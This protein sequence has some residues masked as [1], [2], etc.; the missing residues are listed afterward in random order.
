MQKENRLISRITKQRY[1][2]S[3]DLQFSIALLV[4]LALLAGIFLQAVSS[5][6]ITWYGMSSPLL[7]VFLAAGYVGIVLLLAV[8][9]TYRLVGPFRRLEYEMKLIQAGDLSK[10]LSVR[11]Q[12]DLHIR[13][14]INFVNSFV[15]G[16][17]AAK[18]NEER[19]LVEILSRLERISGEL[20]S[21]KGDPGLCAEL[22][23][24]IGKVKE[25]GK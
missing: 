21:G 20:D 5:A 9:F 1:F 24:L 22:K 7:A 19:L 6:L 3:R 15:A 13:N 23:E 17:E 14:F 8:F 18:K 2:S 25:A 16:F 12:D 11:T 10:R 4:V